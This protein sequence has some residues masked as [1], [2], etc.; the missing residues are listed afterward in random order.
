MTHVAGKS[1]SRRLERLQTIRACDHRF[2][3]SSLIESA[4]LLGVQNDDVGCS[5]RPSGGFLDMHLEKGTNS[6]DIGSAPTVQGSSPQH[7]AFIANG[8]DLPKS[9]STDIQVR[10]VSALPGIKV[11]SYW[12]GNATVRWAATRHIQFTA[13][14]RDLLQPHHVEFVYDPGP[15]V[16][17]QRAFY[18]EITFTR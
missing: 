6:K 12:T 3:S 10:Y 18:G 8:F 1:P 17:I 13:A 14:G 4:S 7:Q 16:G 15:P 11:P 5:V 9:V 2:K